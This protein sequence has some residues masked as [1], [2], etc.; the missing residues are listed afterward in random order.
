M[1]S[2]FHREGKKQHQCLYC[3]QR[4]PCVTRGSCSPVDS[5]L[6]AVLCCHCSPSGCRGARDTL[7]MPPGPCT[8]TPDHRAALW[9]WH[10]RGF[11]PVQSSFHSGR[12]PAQAS[13]GPAGFCAPCFMTCCHD[14]SAHLTGSSNC[15]GCVII[16]F[17]EAH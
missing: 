17:I 16:H 15:D 4:I 9:P 11:I 13:A 7:L 5:P 1:T 8:L 6:T 2:P 3:Q 14:N 10:W 12:F